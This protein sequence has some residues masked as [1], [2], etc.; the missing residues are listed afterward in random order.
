[1]IKTYRNAHSTLPISQI[2]YPISISPTK[3]LILRQQI[4]AD[5]QLSQETWN[6]LSNQIK[7]MVKKCS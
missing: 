3:P 7:E 4:T 5:F 2:K 1:M 6:Q